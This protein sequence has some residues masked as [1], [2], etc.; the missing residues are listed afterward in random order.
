MTKDEK[1]QVA[2]F[3]FSVIGDFINGSQMGR[4]REKALVCGKS[5]PENGKFLFGKKPG[6]VKAR[7]SDG[8]VFIVTA[9]V[10]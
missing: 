10:I 4:G 8:A 1:M 7:S 3:R 9:G 2:V 5:A 6:S